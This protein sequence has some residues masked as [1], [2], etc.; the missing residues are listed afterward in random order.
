MRILEISAWRIPFTPPPKSH[1][2]VVRT[3]DYGGEGHPA[4]AKRVVVAPVS[5]L[6]LK[7]PEAIHTFKL[8]AGPRWSA[9]P[10]SDSGVG[11]NED[12]GEHGY[13][14]VTCED[15]PSPGMNLKWISDVL[16]KLVEEANVCPVHCHGPFTSSYLLLSA[17]RW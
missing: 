13:I 3:L 4:I 12:G 15:Y 1:P 16:D 10:P 8:L 11:I 14:K 2:L 5:Q 17:E 9:S 7:T 6:P